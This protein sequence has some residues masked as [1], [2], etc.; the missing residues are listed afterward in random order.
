MKRTILRQHTKLRLR[1]PG[2]EEIRSFTILGE[3]PIGDGASAICY[4][5]KNDSEVRGTLKEFYPSDIV[6]QRDA[7]GYLRSEAKHLTEQLESYLKPY[8]LLQSLENPF[9]FIPNFEIYA[10]ADSVYIWTP[11]PPCTTFE[12]FLNEVYQNPQKK[13]VENLIQI[14]MTIQQL[15]ICVERLHCAG[16]FHR[17][18]KP[19]NFGAYVRN[20]ELLSQTLCLF[21]I[22]SICS[23][24][25]MNQVMGTEGF[26]SPDTVFTSRS[27]VYSIGATLFYALTKRVYRAKDY[28]HIPRLLKSGELFRCSAFNSDIEVLIILT[29]VLKKTLC[30]E[31]GERY[32]SCE[33]FRNDFEK[34][35]VPLQIAKILKANG[36]HKNTFTKLRKQIDADASKNIRFALQHH[37]YETPILPDETK[38]IS[39]CIYGFGSIGQLYLDMLLK[40]LH[41]PDVTVNLYVIDADCEKEFYLEQRP[42]L[43]DFYSID[44]NKPAQDCYG[45]IHFYTDAKQLSEQP[46]LIFVAE[47]S[48]SCTRRRCR[49]IHFQSFPDASIQCALETENQSLP[50]WLYPIYIKKPIQAKQQKSLEQMA[51]NVHLVWK[52]SLNIPWRKIKAEFRHPYNFNSCMY[53]VLTMRHNLMYMNIDLKTISAEDAASA[54]L[55]KLPAIRDMLICNE[56]ARWV[57]EKIT[58]GYIAKSADLENMSD[59]KPK[60]ESERQH[61]C[62]VPAKPKHVLK[63]W[64]HDQWDHAPEEELQTLDALEQMSVQLHRTYRC[65]AQNV[66]KNENILGELMQN[67]RDCLPEQSKDAWNAFYHWFNTAKDV[68]HEDTGKTRLF[69]CMQQKFLSQIKTETKRKKIEAIVSTFSNNFRPILLAAEYRDYKVDDETLIDQIPFILTYR[70]N[71][72]LAIPFQPKQ[73]MK[74]FYA[75]MIV[76][77]QKIKYLCMAEDRDT[78]RD[79][80]KVLPKLKL[81]KEKNVRSSV[82][83][84]FVDSDAVVKDTDVRAI[85]E[86]GYAVRVLPD[87]SSL[88][89]WLQKQNRSG[90]LCAA[91][92]SHNFLGGYLNDKDIPKYCYKSG[93][94]TALKDT[95]ALSYIQKKPVLL[96]DDVFRLASAAGSSSG[97]PEFQEDYEQLFSIYRKNTPAWKSLCNFL[98]QRQNTIRIQKGS[99]GTATMTAFRILLPA[100]CGAGVKKILEEA[101]SRGIIPD[102]DCEWINTETFSVQM[103]CTVSQRIGFCMLFEKTDVLTHPDRITFAFKPQDSE[104]LIIQT[105][106]LHENIFIHWND[107]KREELCQYDDLLNELRNCGYL[108]NYTYKKPIFDL[109]KNGYLS[110]TYATNAVRT[111]LTNAGRIFEVY[112][113]HKV[114]ESGQFDD[115]VNS[116][117]CSWND[118]VQNEFDLVLTKGLETIL[119]EIKARNAIDNEILYK[120]DSLQNHFSSDLKAVLLVDTKSSIPEHIR[121][122]AEEN[123]ITIICEVD[124]IENIGNVLAEL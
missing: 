12:A 61:V 9:E 8:R 14:L 104:N 118:K 74:N 39:V 92:I 33:A 109:Q 55:D 77:P 63:T 102:Y 36:S 13:P 112:T 25:A 20:E 44:G 54:Y 41:F 23:T 80:C 67:M 110:F 98:Y 70:D 82:E 114:M 122:R 3:K 24:N 45:N 26:M 27:D 107:L 4:Y 48:D 57:A 40:V 105:G 117:V 90:Q 35:F 73:I 30:E 103:H 99:D 81:L 108:L 16:L 69:Q 124:K 46:Q 115:V 49:E 52:K 85:Q 34:V 71:I 47:S 91:E 22:N 11:K 83:F 79:V 42:A 72:T 51:W 78:I 66:R 28:S 62:I 32:P 88:L 38:K 19:E 43:Q 5:A 96:V 64:T 120:L 10:G 75:P 94:L 50:E 119:I 58:D 29:H 121:D 6:F 93:S 18:I 76:N 84:V 95:D 111:L 106:S 7:D 101:L 53:F 37:L 87:V 100:E 1:L 113:Y 68:F 116:Y 123:E 59:L 86:A 97:Q 31:R 2:S 60:D 65:M 15:A 89:E 17:D 56:H 21:D